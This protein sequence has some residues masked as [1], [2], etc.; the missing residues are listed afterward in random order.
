[1]SAL[2]KIGGPLA[3]RALLRCVKEGDA[4][5][6]EAARSA[7][8]SIEFLEDPMAFSSDL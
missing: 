8:E 5:L 6:E 7:L 3:K 1:L 4:V 2:G